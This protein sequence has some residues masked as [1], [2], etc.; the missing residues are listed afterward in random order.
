MQY[1]ESFGNWTDKAVPF[2]VKFEMALRVA[3]ERRDKVIRLRKN[4]GD[5]TAD[6][7]VLTE[8][9]LNLVMDT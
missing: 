5:D 1:S 4:L 8:E 7:A 6:Q 9:D 2:P 3:K